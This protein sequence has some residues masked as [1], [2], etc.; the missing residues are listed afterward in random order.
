MFTAIHWFRTDLRVDDNEALNRAAN[1]ALKAGKQGRLLPVYILE[2]AATGKTPLGFPATGPFRAR[3]LLETLQALRQALRQRGSDLLT[4][5]G[6][7]QV[8][9][10]DLVRQ[11]G[12]QLVTWHSEP[13]HREQHHEQLA[14]ARLQA[15]GAETGRCWGPSLLHPDDLP[16]DPWQQTPD[17]FTRFRRQVEKRVTIREP[18]GALNKY[19]PMPDNLQHLRNSESDKNPFPPE[20]RFADY[21]DFGVEPPRDD[22]RS[23][24]RF[25]GGEQ[26]ARDRMEHYFWTSGRLASYKQERNG[27]LGADYSSKFSAWLANGSLSPRRVWHEVRRFEQERVK[28]DSTYWLIF[29]LLWRDYFRFVMMK[30]GARLFQVSGIASD[31]DHATKA[32]SHRSGSMDAANMEASSSLAVSDK[33]GLATSTSGMH[34]MLDSTGLPFGYA[35][36]SAS[37]GEQKTFEMWRTGNTG[38]RFVDANMRELLLTGYMSKIGRAHV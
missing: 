32:A 16:F 22:E 18:V 4:V 6:L 28:N 26:A 23:V 9:L 3:F 27:L 31:S 38:V 14:A 33:S 11:Y 24:L 15:Q 17:V 37:H 36:P 2:P 20:Y 13:A 34:S 29:E 1:K 7:P 5:R 25:T 35:K 8:V 12:A 30:H 19:P 21:R 10:P